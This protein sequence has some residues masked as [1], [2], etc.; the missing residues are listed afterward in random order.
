[1]ANSYTGCY[2]HFIFGTKYR[3]PLIAP[4]MRPRLWE[5]IGGIAREHKFDALCVGGDVDHAHVLIDMSRTLTIAQSIQLLKGGSS[6]WVNDTF[7]TFGEFHWQT[8]YG[9]F[10]VGADELDSVIY[11]ILHQETHHHNQ[12]FQDEYLSLLDRYGV[13]YD[14]RYLWD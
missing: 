14:E 4:A 8:G 6:K 1:M 2:I 9:A 7:R 12:A 10:S 5:Y 3:H 11:Y 13:A